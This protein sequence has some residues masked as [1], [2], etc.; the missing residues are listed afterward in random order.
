M[1]YRGQSRG[2][3]PSHC[4]ECRDS[5]PDQRWCDFHNAWHPLAC[6]T[7]RRQVK[8]GVSNTCVEAASIKLSESKGLKPLHCPACSETRPS[9]RFRGGRAKA[10]ACKECEDQHPGLRWCPDHAS[11]LELDQFTVTGVGGKFNSVRCTSCRTAASHGVTTAQVL[12]I[13]GSEAPECAA[14]GA[15]G[16]LVIDHDHGHCSGPNGCK[17]CVRGFLCHSC[18]TAE[19]L[20]RSPERAR[21]LANYMERTF[22]ER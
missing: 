8:S 19:G 18:N 4:Q 17:D 21:A 9:H 1:R 5:R 2:K 11:W 12:I 3:T 16:K 6:F 15:L 22:Q 14:C 13:Q 7:P 10:V 20:L